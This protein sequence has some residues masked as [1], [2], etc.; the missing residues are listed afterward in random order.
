MIAQNKSNIL[1]FLLFIPCVFLSMGCALKIEK[2]QRIIVPDWKEYRHGTVRFPS[3]EYHAIFADTPAQQSL[4]L[5][6]R[7]ELPKSWA[8]VF[9]FDPP[10]RPV[11]WMKDMYFPLDILWVRDGVIHSVSENVPADNGRKKYQPEFE[12]DTVIEIEAGAWRKLGKPR[13]LIIDESRSA[14]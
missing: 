14:R 6:R 8:M 5:S 7:R 9:T 12:V 1:L 13:T 10:T 2:P 11:F 4:G 3:H